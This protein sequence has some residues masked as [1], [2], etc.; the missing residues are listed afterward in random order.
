MGI[1]MSRYGIRSLRFRRLHNIQKAMSKPPKTPAQCPVC[2][3]TVEDDDL[4]LFVHVVLH[5]PELHES[6]DRMR[7]GLPYKTMKQLRKEGVKV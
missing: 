3:E 5:H 4:G 1:P 7:R 2:K 6:I